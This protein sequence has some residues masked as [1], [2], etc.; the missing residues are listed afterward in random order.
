MGCD[1]PPPSKQSWSQLRYNDE[2]NPVGAQCRKLRTASGDWSQKSPNRLLQNWS[3]AASADGTNTDP[4]AVRAAVNETTMIAAAFAL[5]GLRP[6]RDPTEVLRRP[7]PVVGPAWPAANFNE[8]APEQATGKGG[9]F[10]SEPGSRRA[11][12]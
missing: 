8:D 7:G 10:R 11:R 4:A 5:T 1:R 6:Q 2:P 9:Q 3:G 12:E